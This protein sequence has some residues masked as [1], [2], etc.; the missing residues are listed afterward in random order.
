MGWPW[1]RDSLRLT[2]ARRTGGHSTAR[3]PRSRAPSGSQAPAGPSNLVP[4]RPRLRVLGLTDGVSTHTPHTPTP[5]RKSYPDRAW[6]GSGVVRRGVRSDGHRIGR[7]WGCFH[8]NPH[9]DGAEFRLLLRTSPF[10]RSRR[11][12]AR[13]HR[14]ATAVSTMPIAVAVCRG[15]VGPDDQAARASPGVAVVAGAV[16]PS[17]TTWAVSRAAPRFRRNRPR[18]LAHPAT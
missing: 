10:H 15:V 8:R 7:T 17:R 9:N 13:P 6:E 12:G 18:S 16:R 14:T 2:C 4:G 3:A 1:C 11:Q 5:P